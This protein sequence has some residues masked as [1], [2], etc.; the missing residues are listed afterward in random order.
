LA[1][2]LPVLAAAAFTF[3]FAPDFLSAAF[4]FFAFAIC[5][6]LQHCGQD[7]Q[8]AAKSLAAMAVK[9]LFVAG[10]FSE[11]FAEGGEVKDRVI[12]KATRAMRLVEDFSVHSVGDHGEHS[13]FARHRQRAN[14]VS[15]A[16]V[17][18]ESLQ[19]V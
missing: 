19:R 6:K 17:A 15:R 3:G 11:G 4:F 7:V 12:A 13:S 2:G 18:T 9:I 5:K 10:E 14:E 8:Q 1:A 16:L